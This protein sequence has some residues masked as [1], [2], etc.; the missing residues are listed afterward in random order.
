MLVMTGGVLGTISCFFAGSLPTVA[1]ALKFD[2]VSAS[3]PTHGMAFD[4]VHWRFSEVA[5][6]AE[7]RDEG[8]S[9]GAVEDDDEEQRQVQD[10]CVWNYSWPTYALHKVDYRLYMEWFCGKRD[11]TFLEI[12][13]LDG[14]TYSNTKLFENSLNWHGMLIEASPSSYEKLTTSRN[15]PKNSL[16]GKAVCPSGQGSLDF[17]AGSDPA[18]SGVPTQ[19]SD[20]EMKV[21]HEQDHNKIIK[22]PCEPLSKMLRDARIDHIDL[23]SLDVEGGELKV[24]E[25]MDWEVTVDVFVIELDGTNVEKDQA[26][27][28]LLKSK[29][30]IYGGPCPL[31]RNEIWTSRAPRR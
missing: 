10:H 31:Y 22:V 6:D 25:T 16:V 13:A 20:E 1:R 15:N 9:N 14:M 19:M 27:R 5:K 21:W 24:L 30:Y 8:A 28:D 3:P 12:G 11:G 17:L 26:V 2:H 18:V 7:P 23:F 4:G 29:G